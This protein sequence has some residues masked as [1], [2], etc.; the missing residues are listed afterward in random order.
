MYIEEFGSMVF[1]EKVMEQ[2]LDG[3]SFKKLMMVRN[4]GM[5]MERPLADVVAE[6]MKNWAVG[7]G[8]THFT[9]WFQPMT[10][11]TA[12]KHDA[13]L[14]RNKEGEPILELKGKTLMKG[15]SDASSFPSGGIRETFE[16]RGYTV[17]DPTSDAFIREDTLCIPTAF[18]SFDGAVL[19]KKTPLLRSLDAINHQAVRLLKQ[20][21]QTTRYVYP[22]VG[23]EQEYFLINRADYAKRRDLILTERT[24]FGAATPKG[25]VLE[26]H[27]YG[28]IRPRVKAFMK[29]L[30]EELWKV[31]IYSKTEH[32]E[33]APC[34]HEMAPIYA[35]ANIAVDNNQLI[36]DIMKKVANRHGFVCLLHE[37]PFEGINGSGKH[38]NW[39]LTTAEG[40]NLLKPGKEPEKNLR[41]MIFLTAVIKAVDD[42]QDLLRVSVAS[43]ANDHRLGG[44]EAPPAI[45]SMYLGDRL[46][47]VVDAIIN[48]TDLKTAYEK[49][50]KKEQNDDRNRTSPFAFTGN[51][52]EFRMPGSAEN[53]SC[54]NYVIN[55]SVA[56]SLKQFADRLSPFA[57]KPEFEDEV[58]KLIR[59]ELIAH[60]RILFE[61]NGYS[62]EWVKEAERRG[63]S[64]YKS[65]PEAFSHYT[66]EKNVNLLKSHGI[67]TTEEELKARAVIGVS[68]YT[69]IVNIE[70]RTMILM[71]EKDIMP[72]V[73]KYSSELAYGIESKQALGLIVDHEMELLTDIN[74][75]IRALNANN[76]KLQ[77]ALKEQPAG[78]F[79]AGMHAFER[80]LPA[81]E[82]ERRIV[83]E[84]E[85]MVDKQ[86]WPYPDYT[87]LL[88]YV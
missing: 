59:E 62:Q 27:Y 86:S 13:F 66:D 64:N 58:R 33:V 18:C 82:E 31:G 56:E 63:L 67:F 30:D 12:E 32:N 57:G 70:A 34:Q 52:F 36:M 11:A 65:T 69:N 83:D 73:I 45:V 10:G 19:D 38:N 17:W 21:G 14:D 61:G 48:K 39:S 47:M 8:A 16:A 81:M 88:Y 24:L 20:F 22:A 6:A 44:N 15:E 23:L 68:K 26:D 49:A 1:N 3:E 74:E 7:K 9:H 54:T 46:R 72:A 75:H 77:E 53:V 43:A 4:E 85:L 55:T 79:E 60:E 37:K 84:L 5:P 80:I 29:E 76:V 28:T 40:E 35:R 50:S 42:Y 78:T 2:L 51:K 71:T 87:D 41:F 25:Q